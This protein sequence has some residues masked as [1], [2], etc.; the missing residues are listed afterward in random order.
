MY[1]AVDV[2]IEYAEEE[3]RIDELQAGKQA[4]DRLRGEQNHRGDKV[5]QRQFLA[6]GEGRFA[7]GGSVDASQ[8]DVSG[9]GHA[10]SPPWGSGV[11]P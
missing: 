4:E 5:L 2:E 6:G 10:H 8:W 3:I 7:R 9:Y 1:H 11:N